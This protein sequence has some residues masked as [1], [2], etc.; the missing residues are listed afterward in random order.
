MID[1]DAAGTAC[2]DPPLTAQ[3]DLSAGQ[4]LIVSFSL[5]GLDPGQ[6]SAY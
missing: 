1:R 6:D 2:P 4:E 5:I 3:R